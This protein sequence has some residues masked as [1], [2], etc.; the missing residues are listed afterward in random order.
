[1]FVTYLN[2]NTN[3]FVTYFNYMNTI[4][5]SSDSEVIV[6]ASRILAKI[7]QDIFIV[8]YN[9]DFSYVYIN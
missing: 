6:Y 8:F 4:D 7:I 9:N 3:M 2:L 1:M 5:I